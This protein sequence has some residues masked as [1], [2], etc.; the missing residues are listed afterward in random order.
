MNQSPKR[1]AMGLITASVVLHKT[2]P[3]QLERLLSCIKESTI[4]PEIYLVDN[5]PNP[6]DMPCFR[7]PGVTYIRAN[8][9]NGYG[10]GHNIAL[11]AI[12][13]KAQFHFVLNPDIYFAPSELEK[14]VAFMALDPSIGQLMPKVIY[15]DGSLQY[16]CKLLPTPADL[17]LRRFS[18]GPLKALTRRQVERFELRHT[19]YSRVL[20]VPYLSGCF[21]L[22]RISAL[23]QVGLFDER[24][25]MYPEDIDITRRMHAQFRTVFY[26]EAVIVHDHARES[27]KSSRALWTHIYNSVRYFNKWGWIWDPQRARFNRDTLRQIMQLSQN[28]LTIPSGPHDVKENEPSGY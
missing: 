27:Y 5:S 12:L 25:F 2:P 24:F 10:A 15:P 21:M 17:F 13:D 23:R 3:A 11:R 8:K 9:N 1:S 18:F 28:G 16:L 26:P 7:L 6:A 14:M 19:N 20:D 4:A 22:F